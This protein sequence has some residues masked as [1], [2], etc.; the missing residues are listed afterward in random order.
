MAPT[1]AQPEAPAANVA[2]SDAAE[3]GLS[4]YLGNLCFRSKYSTYLWN[5]SISAPYRVIRIA[6]M[7]LISLLL[8]A[9]SWRLFIRSSS[10]GALLL[11]AFA[12]ASWQFGVFTVSALVVFALILTLAKQLASTPEVNAG[13][14]AGGKGFAGTH[15]EN[16]LEALTALIQRDNSTPGGLT[17]LAYVEFDVHETAD[18]ELVVL[19]DLHSVLAASAPYENNQ[20]IMQQL[21]GAG[22]QLEAP[23]TTT[24]AKLMQKAQA[25]GRGLY[26]DTAGLQ[27]LTAAQL[28]RVHISGRQGVHVPTLEEFLRCCTSHNLQRSIAVEV[29]SVA[30]DAGRTKFVN[31][32]RQ[33]KQDF[34]QRQDPKLTSRLYKPFAPIAA[35]SFPFFWAPAFGEFGTPM[36]REWALQFRQA[37]VNTRC[38]VWHAVNLSRGA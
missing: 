4:Q 29:K 24:T 14:R 19:H 32:L 36:W 22:L 16:T 5:T 17:T 23:A 28:K 37:G 38:C 1:S 33:Y 8:L 3:G 13:H 26:G 7:T 6:A 2:P 11:A 20:G 34:E 18:K 27:S 25:A 12:L 15:I 9:R 30:S 21:A 35:I 31:L 10:E